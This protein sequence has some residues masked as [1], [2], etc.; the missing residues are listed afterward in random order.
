MIKANKNIFPCTILEIQ[1]VSYI[2]KVGCHISSLKKILRK[3]I[4]NSNDDMNVGFIEFEETGQGF[5][6]LFFLVEFLTDR[7]II[8]QFWQNTKYIEDNIIRSREKFNK[9]CPGIKTVTFKEDFIRLFLYSKM[10][11][12]GSKL[13]HKLNTKTWIVFIIPNT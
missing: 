11:I 3:N 6:A 8:W 9:S 5:N 12:T 4:S 13:Y 7:L 10:S 1:F 2:S